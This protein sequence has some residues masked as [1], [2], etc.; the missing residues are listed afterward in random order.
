MQLSEG[1]GFMLVVRPLNLK[2]MR[3]SILIRGKVLVVLTLG[4]WLTASPAPGQ[5]AATAGGS[6][7]P[8]ATP[9]AATRERAAEK[10]EARRQEIQKRAEA[11]AQ[12]QAAG[13]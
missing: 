3:I 13:K 9:K 8:A 6:S 4:S 12:A 11:K 5:S 2:M 7:N 10:Q 1:R